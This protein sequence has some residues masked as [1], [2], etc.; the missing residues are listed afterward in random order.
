MPIDPDAFSTVAVTSFVA[1]DGDGY[2]FQNHPECTVEATNLGTQQIVLLNYLAAYQP[3]YASVAERRIVREVHRYSPVLLSVAP[4]TGDIKQTNI[5]LLAGHYL[6][7]GPDARHT[8]VQLRV[9]LAGTLGEAGGAIHVEC[10]VLQQPLPSRP[11]SESA[12]GVE[13]QL[14]RCLLEPPPISDAS[15]VRGVR[16]LVD[17]GPFNGSLAFSPST[18]SMFNFTTG[19]A[20]DNCLRYEGTLFQSGRCV[21]AGGFQRV[22]FNSSSSGGEFGSNDTSLQICTPCVAGHFSVGGDDICRPCP[23]GSFNAALGASLCYPCAVDTFAHHPGSTQCESC[24]SN[25]YTDYN[26]APTRSRCFCDPGFVA[27]EDLRRL[28]ERAAGVFRNYSRESEALPAG[29][30]SAAPPGVLPASFIS[31]T[32]AHTF[33]CVSCPAGALCDAVS[34]DVRSTP[35]YWLDAQTASMLLC[36]HEGSC[37][38]EPQATPENSAYFAAP[39]SAASAA[40]M[41]AGS[42][43]LHDSATACAEHRSGYLCAVCE[44][45]YQAQAGAAGSR[46]SSCVL[47]KEANGPMVVGVVA[48]C[49][50]YLC[51]ALFSSPSTTHLNIILLDFYQMTS[52]A[53]QEGT[54][55]TGGAMHAILSALNL[56]ADALLQS[57]RDEGVCLL[58]TNTLSTIVL[59]ALMGPMLL[60]SLGILAALALLLPA[61]W[62]PPR[63]RFRKAAWQLLLF[64]FLGSIGGTLELLGCRR[65]GTRRLL[66]AAPDVECWRGDHLLVGGLAIAWSLLLCFLVPVGIIYFVRKLRGRI[67]AVGKATHQRHLNSHSG[68]K[69]ASAALANG[70]N[71]S[72]WDVRT[73]AAQPTAHAAQLDLRQQT[74]RLYDGVAVTTVLRGKWKRTGGANVAASSQQPSATYASGAAANSSAAGATAASRSLSALDDLLLSHGLLFVSYTRRWRWFEALYLVRRVLVALPFALLAQENGVALLAWLAA[75]LLLVHSQVRVFYSAATQ[76][77]H[78]VSLFCLLSLCLLQQHKDSLASGAAK[79]WWHLAA[80]VCV[81]TPPL[82]FIAVHSISLP[83]RQWLQAKFGK[84]TPAVGPAKTAA[85]IARDGP[86]ETA[87]A[88]TSVTPSPVTG[89]VGA[90][91]SPVGRFLAPSAASAAIR[92]TTHR[93]PSGSVGATPAARAAA[94]PAAASPA[95]SDALSPIA[96]P[97]AAPSWPSSPSVSSASTVAPLPA[98]S[99]RLRPHSSSVE[100]APSASPTASPPSA[101]TTSAPADQLLR[102]SASFR[103]VLANTPARNRMQR[104]QL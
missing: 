41:A 11:A 70:S 81:L 91:P 77:L 61:R 64:G 1:A 99:L 28:F 104:V 52:L 44:P 9:T 57:S 23:T 8:S 66:I 101:A 84:T 42:C 25:S 54:L 12:A 94:S 48:V 45:G 5:L 13:V 47:C 76:T 40:T 96:S 80:W 68:L 39:E 27:S 86:A 88:F 50:I 17:S 19:S 20:S 63:W 21:C 35:G 37:C 78:Q 6:Y 67:D 18:P 74:A 3:L 53:L 79:P 93:A 22:Q 32:G 65:I 14:V 10:R 73:P 82:L 46:R 83:L 59:R 103:I 71:V 55:S 2:T 75:A 62:A 69:D 72:L 85:T 49:L 43:S 60:C 33:Q 31:P 24:P 34:G 15:L 36:P 56:H 26:L 38:A 29:R 30:V 90:A 95:A 58:P 7:V 16:F 92:P 51:Y 4:N 102:P 89:A 100:L 97:S 98:P 87:S